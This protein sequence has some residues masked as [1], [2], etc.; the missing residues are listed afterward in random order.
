MVGREGRLA[1]CNTKLGFPT[2]VEDE[3]DPI[4]WVFSCIT[5]EYRIR[6]KKQKNFIKDDANK[7][8]YKIKTNKNFIYEKS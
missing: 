7:I 6:S 8:L 4:N 5:D 1:Y 2:F 3:N